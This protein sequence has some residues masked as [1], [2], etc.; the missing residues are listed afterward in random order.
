MRLGRF[1]GDG[2]MTCHTCRKEYWARIIAFDCP[3]THKRHTIEDCF[4]K[5]QENSYDY[6]GNEAGG[7]SPYLYCLLDPQERFL[8]NGEVRRGL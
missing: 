8:H 1:T 3:L 7:A 6:R 2:E 4:Q 5:C